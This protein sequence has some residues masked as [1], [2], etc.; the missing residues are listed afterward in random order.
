MN[1]GS[2]RLSA[3]N[4]RSSQHKPP[5]DSKNASIDLDQVFRER[6][7]DIFYMQSLIDEHKNQGGARGPT[8]DDLGLTS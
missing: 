4:A 2:S 8:S 5:T 3:Y 1:S 6:G 7:L